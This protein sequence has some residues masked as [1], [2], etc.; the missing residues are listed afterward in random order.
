MLSCREGSACPRLK[1]QLKVEFEGTERGPLYGI[2][3]PKAGGALIY[4]KKNDLPSSTSSA[5]EE[6]IVAALAQA[7]TEVKWSSSSGFKTRD[8]HADPSLFLRRNV[9]DIP[10]EDCI[11]YP[12]QY[13]LP[14]NTKL[15]QKRDVANVASMVID[16]I[17][18]MENPTISTER[19]LVKLV[20][21][22]DIIPGNLQENFTH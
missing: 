20:Q 15:P 1:E 22:S 18:E 4:S 3:I 21:N 10:K 5:E 12:E 2:G 7:L 16:T 8:I 19:Q 9:V 17:E 13:I 6:T 14:N 11:C